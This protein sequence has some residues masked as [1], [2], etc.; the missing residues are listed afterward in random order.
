MQRLLPLL[1]LVLLSGVRA[2]ADAV[3]VIPFYNES[4]SS[5]LDWIS[6][7][8]SQT[9]REALASRGM[10]VVEREDRQEVYR[11]LSIRPHAQ[12]TRASIIKVAEELDA[13]EVIH[14]RF[15]LVA[16][17]LGAPAGARGS[18]WITAR[19]LDMR[20]LRSGPEFT[21][22]GPLEDLAACLGDYRHLAGSLGYKRVS[23]M[24]PLDPVLEP[25]LLEADFQR[26]WED[27]LFI[28][29]KL[30]E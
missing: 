14:G 22:F 28:F 15:A 6:E 18:L 5:N 7:S 29:E 16:P 23:W 8:L 12:L 30:A 11:R 17:G 27:S 1:V 2:A 4:A 10:L 25:A 9:V 3:L 20:R 21:E 13:S 26:D 24:A 19:T